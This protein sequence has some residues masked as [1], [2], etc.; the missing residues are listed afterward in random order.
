M[1][2]EK[3][4]QNVRSASPLRIDVH[5]DMNAVGLRCVFAATIGSYMTAQKRAGDIGSAA[6]TSPVFEGFQRH[7]PADGGAELP[8][9]GDGT[10]VNRFESKQ[11]GGYL[12][13]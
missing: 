4:L 13:L 12:L 6:S 1:T 8:L 3:R 11:A 10:V 7:R 2:D 9:V 5:I